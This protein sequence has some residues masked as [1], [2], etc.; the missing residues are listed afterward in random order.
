V[1]AGSAKAAGVQ[2]P[3]KILGTS[4]PIAAE[5]SDSRTTK[6]WRDLSPDDQEAQMLS[7]LPVELDAVSEEGIADATRKG[8]R[9]VPFGQGY[10]LVDD[11]D[12]AIEED[13]KRKVAAGFW[14][15][16]EESLGPDEDYFGDDLTSLG[17][18]EL[19][20]HREL[21]EYAR[22]IAWELPLL[23]RT[24]LRKTWNFGP[25]N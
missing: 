21:R 22:L 20:K 23:S 13:D 8:K 6:S 9:G 14:A 24:F 10:D 3:A 2:A 4:T 19:K 11:A 15:E 1:K 18:G 17:H 25:P 7:T 5:M 16:G 12:F